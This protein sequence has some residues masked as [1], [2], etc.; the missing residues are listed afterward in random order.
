MHDA[1]TPIGR[2]WYGP[3]PSLDRKPGCCRQPRR[4]F[5]TRLASRRARDRLHKPPLYHPSPRFGGPSVWVELSE[6]QVGAQTMFVMSRSER[7]NRRSGGGM[8]IVTH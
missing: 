6:R 4:D 7:V 8:H 1:T 3:I 5:A 2:G